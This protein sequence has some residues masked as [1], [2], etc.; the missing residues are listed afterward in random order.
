MKCSIENCN[1]LLNCKTLCKFHYDLKRRSEKE[2]A[3]KK[4]KKNHYN[5]N[6]N[7][8]KN[9]VKE[10]SR[11]LIGRFKKAL[12][13]A[14]RAGN[15]WNLTFEEYVVALGNQVCYYCT[16]KLSPSGSGLDRKD[17]H[18]GYE[19]DNVVPCCYTCNTLKRDLLSHKE[20][21]Q[22]IKL[23]KQLRSKEDI[24]NV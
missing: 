5:E 7:L 24:W 23:L 6:S 19:I 17:N 22:V 13:N 4:Q 2:N 15:N 1:N 3:I 14:P 12:Y 21:I 16:G 10:Y 8:I 18:R 11:T 9:K 20:T